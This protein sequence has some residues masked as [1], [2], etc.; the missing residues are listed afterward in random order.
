M[1]FAVISTSTTFLL[2]LGFLLLERRRIV[3]RLPH[4]TCMRDELLPLHP[5]TIECYNKSR[6]DSLFRHM[7]RLAFISVVLVVAAVDD[8][9]ALVRG[10]P[11]LDSK[12]AAA[13]DFPRKMLTPLY[14]SSSRVRRS[15]ACKTEPFVKSGILLFCIV[16]R[17]TLSYNLGKGGHHAE[18]RP[19]NEMFDDI[20]R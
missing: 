1:H 15:I 19:M 8:T 18:K 12:I 20:V 2:Q 9:S 16:N 4:E 17:R 14:L 5:Q 10:V 7:G 3:E 6:R 13:P 11:N